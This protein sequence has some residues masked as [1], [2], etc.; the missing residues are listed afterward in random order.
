MPSTIWLVR[1]SLA[2]GEVFPDAAPR[3]SVWLPH[4]DEFSV[5]LVTTVRS[6]CAV[7]H[8]KHDLDGNN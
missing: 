3:T 6:R 5:T 8:K 4:D 2:Y 7:H 1:V